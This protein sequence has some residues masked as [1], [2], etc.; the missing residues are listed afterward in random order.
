MFQRMVL[1]AAVFYCGGCVAQDSTMTG[2]KLFFGIG[3]DHGGF[4]FRLDG[5]IIPAMGVFVGAG[6]NLAGVGW[7]SGV[8]LRIRPTHRFCPY[9][10]AMYGY[11]AAIRT[12]NAKGQYVGGT[13]FNGPSFGCGFE[14]R[15]LYGT[16][17]MQLGI[18]FPVR[19][20]EAIEAFEGRE[21]PLWPVLITGGVHF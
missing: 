10:T 17:Y 20:K 7:N 8:H 9:A 15:A 3:I 21:P 5:R 16:N 2:Q 6:Y 18:L 1:A 12:E 4:G 14:M 19:S 13:N 11:N